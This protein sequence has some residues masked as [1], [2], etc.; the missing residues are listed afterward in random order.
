MLGGRLRLMDGGW[1]RRPDFRPKRPVGGHGRLNR[2]A[3]ATPGRQHSW[4]HR[5]RPSRQRRQASAPF[6]SDELTL[7]VIFTAV[8]DQPIGSW[9]IIASS[10]WS[11]DPRSAS[12]RQPCLTGRCTVEVP[13][14][15]WHQGRPL[16]CARSA[17]IVRQ[18]T[19]GEGASGAQSSP[20][21]TQYKNVAL[22]R[23]DRSKGRYIAHAV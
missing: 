7:L 1:C 14:C 22:R 16:R 4:Q 12:N 2:P 13:V 20:H 9:R 11:A 6:H 3:E 21:K 23:D 10:L 8:G 17:T 18:C 19:A 15:F 5:F